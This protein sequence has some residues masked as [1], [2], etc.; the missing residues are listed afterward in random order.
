MRIQRQNRQLTKELLSINDARNNKWNTDWTNT[1]IKE[2]NQLGIIIYD[3]LDL[4]LIIPYIDWTPFFQSWE[5]AGRYP[6]I[7]NDEVVGKEATQL[8]ADAKVLLDK[9]LQEELINAKAV[10]GIF[11]AQSIG[12]DVEINII[13]QNPTETQLE[14]NHQNITLHHLRQQIKYRSF[15]VDEA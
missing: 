14:L 7:L 13:P 3:N 4:K 11:P 6:D 1:T 2:P 12:D 10:I 5:L 15:L 8:H 9:I